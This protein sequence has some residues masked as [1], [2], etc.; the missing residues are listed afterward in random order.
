M[1]NFMENS[2]N[3]LNA[4]A[5]NKATEITNDIISKFKDKVEKEGGRIVVNKNSKGWPEPLFENVSDSLKAEIL[6][7][8]VDNYG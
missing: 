1:E 3:M 5:L 7:Y 2:M 8:K 6:K 4:A